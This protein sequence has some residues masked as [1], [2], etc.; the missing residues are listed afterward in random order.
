MDRYILTEFFLTYGWA[1]IGV[2]VIMG[3]ITFSLN[4]INVLPDRCTMEPPFS[5]VEY[6]A[7]EEGLLVLGLKSNLYNNAGPLS[8]T[9]TCEDDSAQAHVAELAIARPG[10]RLNG[11]LLFD[12][13]SAEENPLSAGVAVTYEIPGSPLGH[14]IHGYVRVGRK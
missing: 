14:T 9:L 3:T 7:S 13:G 1:L 11:S 10:E 8:I 6:G 12:C 5:C 2:V 4:Y